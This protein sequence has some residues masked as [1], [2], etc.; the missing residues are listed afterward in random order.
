MQAKLLRKYNI[1]LPGLIYSV[2]C[3]L[4]NIYYLAVLSSVCRFDCLEKRFWKVILEFDPDG[5]LLR[6]NK[7]LRRGR[8]T[9]VSK[10]LLNR[11]LNLS[12][13]VYM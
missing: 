3:C 13:F 9:Y 6:K 7:R 8:R 2:M 12:S 10:V 11:C 1:L 4:Y 5:V